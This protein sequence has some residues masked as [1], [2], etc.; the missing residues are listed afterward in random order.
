MIKK[1]ASI[2]NLSYML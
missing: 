1:I 2:S